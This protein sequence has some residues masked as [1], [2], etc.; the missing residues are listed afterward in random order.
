MDI[1]LF[2]LLWLFYARDLTITAGNQSDDIGIHR[3]EWSIAGTVRC[4][5]G[6]AKLLRWIVT[7]RPCSGLH[8]ISVADLFSEYLQSL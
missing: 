5:R 4:G 7:G 3:S 6:G 2:V 1:G 8:L